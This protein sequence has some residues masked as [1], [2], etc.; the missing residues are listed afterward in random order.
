MTRQI[1]LDATNKKIGRL[2]TEIASILQGKDTPAFEKH[3]LDN[4]KVVVVNARLLDTTNRLEEGY[5][6]YS[7]YPGGLKIET[8]AHLQKR[9]GVEALLKHAVSGML[10]KNTH[11][12]RLLKQ[13]IIEE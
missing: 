8:G 10:P 13:L 7:G 4:T 12:S 3:V 6:S 1:T 11:R 2:A 5:K 9:K